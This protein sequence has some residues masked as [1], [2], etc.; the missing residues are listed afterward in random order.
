[1]FHV[2]QQMKQ[3]RVAQKQSIGKMSDPYK[4]PVTICGSKFTS[5]GHGCKYFSSTA[6]KF[7]LRG[8]IV[9]AIYL[10]LTVGMGASCTNPCS[11]G[12]GHRQFAFLHHGYVV[13]INK[14][15]PWFPKSLALGFT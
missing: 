6:F 11:R 15:S 5:E 4:H 7:T 12:G 13:R 8:H 9:A 10:V 2:T 14:I 3:F 1:M